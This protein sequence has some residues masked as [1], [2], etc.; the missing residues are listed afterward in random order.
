MK[1]TDL[2]AVVFDFD[3]V[4]TDNRVYVDQDGRESVACNRADG[5]AFDLFRRLSLPVFILSTETNKVVSARGNKLR[6]P[7]FQ[8][9]SDKAAALADLCVQENLDSARILFIGND[10]N[11]LTAMRAC[12]YSACPADSHPRILAVARFVLTRKGGEGVAREI[13]EDLLGIDPLPVL[14]GEPS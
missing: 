8:G 6:V 4:L 7:V 12:G 11:D 5:L 9:V 10:L 3:G 2:D 13:V 14:Y 1:V